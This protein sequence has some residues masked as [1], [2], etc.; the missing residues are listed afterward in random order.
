MIKN[1]LD[2]S[3]AGL[4]FFAFGFAFSFGSS[5]SGKSYSFIGDDSFF[6]RGNVDP[7]VFFFQYAFSA[8]A[9]TIVAG[10]VAERCKMAAYLGYSFLLT[11]F[12]YPVVVHAFWA[13]DGY[14]SIANNHALIGMGAIDFSGSGVVHLTGGYAA[15]YAACVLGARK[16]R[17]YDKDGNPL[18][19]LGFTKGHSVALQMLGTM[20]LW[21]CWYGFNSGSALLLTAENKGR[22]AA[23]AAVNTTLSAAAATLSA[24]CTNGL[25]AQYRTGEFAIDVVMAMNGW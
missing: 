20:L 4:A 21:F 8:T 6:L 3:G 16:G 11:G 5:S 13:G 7:A 9:V 23:A 18:A 2:A 1:L 24:L 22:I 25:I 14:F 17:F 10:T 12:V 15:L 19:R